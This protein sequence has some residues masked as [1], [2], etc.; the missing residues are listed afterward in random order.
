MAHL[1]GDSILLEAE[2]PGV[3]DGAEGSRAEET[4]EAGSEGNALGR[5]SEAGGLEPEGG[6]EGIESGNFLLAQGLGEA[7]TQGTAQLKEG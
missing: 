6:A 7:V 4:V 5:N 2:L 3:G 1:R